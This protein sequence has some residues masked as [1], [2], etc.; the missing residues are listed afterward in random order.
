VIEAN[1]T[2]PDKT[3]EKWTPKGLYSYSL[4]YKAMWAWEIQANSKMGI[5][6]LQ[7]QK[8]EVSTATP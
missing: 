5:S 6:A 3:I 7:I 8:A 4:C 1:A 2:S